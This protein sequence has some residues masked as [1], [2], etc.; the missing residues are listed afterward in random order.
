M[1]RMSSNNDQT[2]FSVTITLIIICV[3]FI[4]PLG[5]WF[6]ITYVINGSALNSVL[7]FAGIYAFALLV[8]VMYYRMGVQG[9]ENA[10]IAK[11]TGDKMKFIASTTFAAFFIVL[12]TIC[13]LAVNPE[14]ITIFENSVGIWFIGIMGNSEFC[15]EIF[16]SDIFSELKKESKD[17]HIFNQ[18]FLLTRFNKENIDDFIEY[19]KSDCKS[20]K[21]DY[22][23]SLPFDFTP[24]FVNE[25]Q[26]TKLRNLVSLK[27]LVG[28][29]TWIYGSSVLSLI[30]SI[31]GVTMKRF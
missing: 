19:F 26:L 16:K 8:T 24:N 7:L 15:N 29:F 21:G 9:D 22:D 4:V 25:G 23:V 12:L 2:L 30:I 13:V 3:T 31:I 27:H 17:P 28:Y 18:N 10:E 11:V 14:L 1:Y 20:D 6:S 5:L